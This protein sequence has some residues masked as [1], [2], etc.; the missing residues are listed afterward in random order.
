LTPFYA[1]VDR[2]T[3]RDD[4]LI[5]TGDY[6]DVI[7]L[8]GRG[9]ASD[10]VTFGVWYSS[11]AHQAQTIT[12]MR[13]RP[14]LLTI[15]LSETEFRRRYPQVADYVAREYVPMTDIASSEAGRVRILVN[16]ARRAT[17]TD[18]ATGWLCFR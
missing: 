6:A 2:C 13:A 5:V 10:G 4:R 3:S 15:L 12:E 17:R 14:A 11:V 7:V 9:F 1:Y 16:R 18:P 8:A